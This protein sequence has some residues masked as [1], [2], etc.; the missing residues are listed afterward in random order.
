MTFRNKYNKSE[1]WTD[2]FYLY[3]NNATTQ[4]SG[5]ITDANIME[6]A[7]LKMNLII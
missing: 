5:L 7:K 4:W 3:E 1:A 6:R 2:I